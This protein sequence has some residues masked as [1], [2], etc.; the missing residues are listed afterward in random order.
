MTIHKQVLLPKYDE[1]RI[2]AMEEARKKQ[3]HFRV[4]TW[5]CFYF[6]Y[7]A[8]GRLNAEKSLKYREFV[9]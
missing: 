2:K 1:K 6:T 7:I 8:N 4:E 5:E 3:K 9:L